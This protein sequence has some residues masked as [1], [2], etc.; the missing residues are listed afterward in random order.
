MSPE[1]QDNDYI[2]SSSSRSAKSSVTDSTA[3][4]PKSFGDFSLGYTPNKQPQK[5]KNQSPNSIASPYIRPFFPSNFNF[6][7]KPDTVQRTHSMNAAYQN[8][9]SD[10]SG[11]PITNTPVGMNI[12]GGN[13]KKH[14]LSKK[15][16]VKL[17]RRVNKKT[18]RKTHKKTLKRRYKRSNRKT[19]HKH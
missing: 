5:Y 4:N 17:N 13:I 16:N 12:G 8:F 19:K 6:N 18:K 11:G 1:S 15:R 14:R 7:A 3:F 10:T 2:S 9:K